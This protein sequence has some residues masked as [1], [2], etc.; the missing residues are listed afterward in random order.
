MTKKLL[1]TLF[2]LLISNE[3]SA[4]IIN[5]ESLRKVTDTSGWS[6]S[7]SLNIDLKKNT[8]KIFKINNKI[9]IQYKN[10]KNLVLLMNDINYERFDGKSIISN[11]IQ[12]FRYNYKLTK[13]TALEAFTQSQFNSISKVDFRWLLGTGLR[14]KLS[15]SEN[16][17]FYLG[18]LIMYE[19]DKST[20][21]VPVI[22]KDVR[23]STYFSF[24]LYPTEN[25]SIVSTTY[26]QP[27]IDAF[28]DYRISS[29]SSIAFSLYKNL[30]FK[31]TFNYFFDEFPVNGIP[32]TQYAFT[33]G[34]IYSFD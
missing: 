31:S 2:L 4:Q 19:Y 18:S 24:S 12:H 20:E 6:G 26:Y 33:N 34:L 9:H 21:E 14:F 22:N 16:Y 13:R 32:K 10:K 27:K 17:K 15:Q 23:S 1:T 7:I 11:S 30:G 25:I 29:E 8:A 3:L 28:K 5:T